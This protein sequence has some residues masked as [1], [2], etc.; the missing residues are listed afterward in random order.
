MSEFRLYQC[1]CCVE[2]QTDEERFHEEG[3]V[4][5][6]KLYAVHHR[7]FGNL[8]AFTG[9]RTWHHEQ[10]CPECALN[11]LPDAFDDGWEPH[12]DEDEANV[13]KLFWG[14]EEIA[15]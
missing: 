2:S 10:F 11:T 15:A 14:R 5:I 9:V 4:E 6:T 12:F 3:W 7:A 8:P 13:I 1:D